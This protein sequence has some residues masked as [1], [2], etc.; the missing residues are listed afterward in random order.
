M[1]LD[2]RFMFATGIENSYPVITG[3]DGKDLRRDE[4]ASCHHYERWREDFDLV[5]ELGIAHLRYGPPYY[6]THTRPGKYDWQFADETFARLKELSIQPIADLC[7]FGV[8]DWVGGFQDP[9]WPELFADYA[10]AFAERFPWVELFTPVNEIRVCAHFSAFAGAWNERLKSRRSMVNAIRN[11]ARATI[12]AE[13][14]I[15]R[16]TP[17]ARFIQSEATTY[18]H[19][20]T[21]RVQR[22]AEKH[23]EM[24]FLP[25]DLCYGHDVSANMYQ[26]LLDNGFTR[27]EYNWFLNR[28]RALNPS[29]IM[30]NDYYASNEHSVE[31]NGEI[32]ASG[33]LFGYYVLTREYHRRYELPIMYTETNNLFGVDALHWLRKEWAN[34]RRLRE[35]GVPLIGFTWYSLTDQMDW[36]TGLQQD[37]WRVTPVGLFNLDRQMRPVG[38]R[39]KRLIAEW[40]NSLASSHLGACAR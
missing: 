8:P 30:G 37:N 5:R 21:P 29:C 4:M 19:P 31:D 6:R 35:D 1:A 13:E 26:Y 7:H 28:G 36:D 32:K 9:D 3:K 33:E 20:E 22:E 23:N 10:A 39:Y 24:R 40:G 18:Y 17:R 15:L 11:M 14:A 38:H 2:P 12:L 16:V 34:V 27:D 25:L